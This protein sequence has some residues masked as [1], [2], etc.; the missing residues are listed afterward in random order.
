[1]EVEALAKVGR[2]AEAR[3]KADAFRRHTPNSLFLPAVQSAVESI[4]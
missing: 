3:A 1:M 2:S 4:P